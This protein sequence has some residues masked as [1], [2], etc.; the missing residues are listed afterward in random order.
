MSTSTA[1]KYPIAKYTKG[2]DYRT[3]IQIIR[4]KYLRDEISYKEAK[5]QVESLLVPMNKKAEALA[6]E[7]GMK[8]KKLTFGY[9]F[10]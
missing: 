5:T 4:G 6:K 3:Q 7:H 1:C 2:M 9:V 8:F 10:R